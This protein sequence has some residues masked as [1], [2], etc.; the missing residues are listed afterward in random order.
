MLCKL[1][2][3]KGEETLDVLGIERVRELQIFPSKLSNRD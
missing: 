3:F 1:G 2:N